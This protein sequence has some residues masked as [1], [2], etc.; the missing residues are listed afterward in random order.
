LTQ[1]RLQTLKCLVPKIGHSGGIHRGFKTVDRCRSAQEHG[2][3]SVDKRVLSTVLSPG[4]DRVR[5]GRGPARCAARGA[6]LAG[7]AGLTAALRIRV[8][9]PCLRC[10]GRLRPPRAGVCTRVTDLSQASASR[11]SQAAEIIGACRMRGSARLC[12]DGVK[13]WIEW[14]EV[15]RNTRGIG[16]RQIHDGCPA[17]TTSGFAALRSRK[18]AWQ[19]GLRARVQAVLER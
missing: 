9:R 1:S 14:R 16:G 11:S 13:L 5:C 6:A 12:V 18:T 17:P 2:L 4:G 10:E 8:L 7:G 3:F 19:A 15:P